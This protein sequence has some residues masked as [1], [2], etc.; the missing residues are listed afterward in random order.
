MVHYS[1]MP[2]THR[3]ASANRYILAAL[4]APRLAQLLALR[5]YTPEKIAGGKAL[6]DRAMT[7]LSVKSREYSEQV[8]TQEEAKEAWKEAVHQYQDFRGIARVVFKRD[9]QVKAS[10]GLTGGVKPR[11]SEAESQIRTCYHN[12]LS[13]DAITTALTDYRYSHAEITAMAQRLEAAISLKMLYDKERT[14]AQQATKD[15]NAAVAL[16]DEWI[17]DFLIIARIAVQD[18]PELMEILG[19]TVS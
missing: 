9:P 3:L 4:T 14:E 16:L 6:A 13:S 8:A 18:Q 19:D 17:G 5:S 11:R 12:A 15:R 1:Q 7:S 10:L 2:L